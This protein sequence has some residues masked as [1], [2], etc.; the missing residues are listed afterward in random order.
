M[1]KEQSLSLNPVKISGY[2]GRLMCC[3]KYEQDSYEELI[4]LTPPQ[5]SLVETPEGRG[6]VVD[7]NLLTGKMKVRL[8]DRRDT[9]PFECL[10]DDVKVI[11]RAEIRL[12]KEELE[13]A[14]QISDPLVLGR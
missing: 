13:Q 7:A 1:A 9:A 11:R 2:C 10:R 14:K 12:S 3:L 8:D 6:M 5:G 4:K